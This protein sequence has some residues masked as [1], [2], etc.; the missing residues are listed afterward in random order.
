M[1]LFAVVLERYERVDTAK[2]AFLLEANCGFARIDAKQ[3]AAAARGI[4][5]ERI[6]R[7]AAEKLQAALR[8]LG[9]SAI[10]QPQSQIVDNVKARRVH[11]LVPLPDGLEVRWGNITGH[12]T[13]AWERVLVISAAVVFME[14][15][16]KV[17]K[18]TQGWSISPNSAL[19]VR[20][21]FQTETVNRDE[22]RDV[23]MAMI[24]LE[25]TSGMCDHILLRA[26]ELEYKA[27]LGTSGQPSAL[28]NFAL[29]LAMIGNLSTA[30]LI[31]DETAELIAAAST[32]PRLPREPRFKN[33]DEFDLYQR[34]LLAKRMANGQAV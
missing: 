3:K 2:L 31:T 14:E 16:Q 13:F 10:V 11:Y 4:V 9:H 32:S 18:V 8:N 34:W 26:T 30:A 23:A 1:E 29:L 5:A 20:P 22:S 21:D 25:R 27:I 17:L 19:G 12:E 7:P 15:T 28:Q 24:S 6:A 33:E